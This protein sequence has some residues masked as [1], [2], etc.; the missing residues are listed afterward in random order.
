MS[1]IDLYAAVRAATRTRADWD[2]TV[3]AVVTSIR[4]Y[5]PQPRNV[6]A[7]LPVPAR[8]GHER[9]VPLHVEPDGTFSV[10]ALVTRPGQATSIHDHTTWCVVAV[11]GGA[12]REERFRLDATGTC[13]EPIGDRVD[14]CGTVTGFA[15]PGDIHRVSNCGAALGVSLHIYGTDIR[16]T[17]SSV[18][19]T[20]DLPIVIKEQV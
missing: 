13:L 4:P 1:L 20:Y 8:R 11:I 16:R 12:E 9:S 6:L 19:R 3:D 2:T 10:V 17:T 15:P 7:R 5:L 18:R 14:H